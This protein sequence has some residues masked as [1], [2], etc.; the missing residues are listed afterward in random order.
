LPSAT[1]NG[2]SLLDGNYDEEDSAA[3]FQQALNAWRGNPSSETKTPQMS[4]PQTQPKVPQEMG[5]DIVYMII[6]CFIN[7]NKIIIIIFF[8]L[9]LVFVLCIRVVIV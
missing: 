5:T 9:F 8:A 2:A 4:Q 3:S 1:N 6:N 7:Y